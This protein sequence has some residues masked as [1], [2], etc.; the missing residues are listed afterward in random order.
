VATQYDLA[1]GEHAWEIE[2]LFLTRDNIE[3]NERVGEDN[4]I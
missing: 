4:Y 1:D 3:A 2:P